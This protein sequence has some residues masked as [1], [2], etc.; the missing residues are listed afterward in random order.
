MAVALPAN[1]ETVETFRGVT[2]YRLKSNG[3]TVVLVP[4]RAAPVVTFMVVYHV[5]S[6]N[7]APGNTGSAH[8]LEHMI[9]NKSTTNFGRANGHRTFQEVLHVAGA[10]AGSSNMTT[11]YDRMNGYSTVPADKLEL[12][13]KIEADRLGRGLILESERQTEMSVVRNEFEISE[14]NPQQAL[15]KA[16]IGTA[17][18]AHPY[19][20]SVIGYRSDIEGVTIDKL[21]E[22][23]RTYFWPD[24]AEAVI[25]GDFDTDAAL[26]MIDREFGG[27]KRS[28]QP[29]PKV[30]TVEPEQEGQRRDVVRRPGTVGHVLIGYMRPGVADPDHWV[31]EVLSAVLADGANARLRKLLVDKGIATSING[32]QLQPDGSVSLPRRRDGRPRSKPQR[33]RDGARRPR[34]PTSRATASPAP[35][36]GARSSR[37][38]WRQI[39]EREGTYRLARTIGE[40]IASGEW[41]RAY[42]QIDAIRA[43][44]AADVQR[45]VAKYLVNDRATV[46]WFVAETAGSARVGHA[47]GRRRRRLR[48][49]RRF[50]LRPCLRRGLRRRPRRP[51]PLHRRRPPT[52][53]ASQP[54]RPPTPCRSR[55]ARRAACCRTASALA[56]VENHAAPTVAI[57][58]IVIGGDAD[59]ARGAAGAAVAGREDARSRDDVAHQGADRRADRGCRRHARVATTLA[60]TSRAP[61]ASRAT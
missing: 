37:S 36:S 44:T 1:V 59:R 29:I 23:Y 33:G 43:V 41:K 31:F 4:Q 40:A 56:I 32:A 61:A 34:S 53:H 7:E 46:G 13:M 9:F 12:A 5:G 54:T 11:W 38:K 18:Q 10:D 19:H 45:V 49:Q 55:S 8:L 47:R 22:H 51:A 60:D 30:I 21:R 27:F 14:N 16:V 39:R 6:R 48:R 42:S 28:T 2:Q 17:V 24:N 50:R 57:R 26:A 15:F 52:S 35:K 58:G 3:M 25:V 20:W